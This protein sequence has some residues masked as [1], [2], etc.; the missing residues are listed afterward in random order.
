MF[1]PH[2]AWVCAVSLLLSVSAPLSA[3]Q[4]SSITGC[5]QDSTRAAIPGAAVI[6]TGSDGA[7]RFQTQADDKGCFNLSGLR[8]GKYRL[9]IFAEAFSAYEADIALEDPIRL[10]DIVLEIH[11]IQAEVVVTATRNLAPANTLGSSVDVIDRSRIE[12]SHIQTASD[13]LRNIGGLA[14]VRTGNAGGI[15]TLFTRGGNSDY[16]K[17]LVDGIPVNQPGGTYDF[18][19]L[20]ADNISTIE[21]VRG[22]QSALFGSDAL[23]GIVQMFT[24]RGTA[25][26]EAEYSLEG[27]N[28]G[29]LKQSTA[30]RGAWKR[31]DWSNTFSRLDTDN[32]QPNN[33]YR[34]AGYF[35]N[36]GFALDSK[37]TFRGTL[38]HVSSRIATPGVN[39]PGFTSFG[40]ND[41]AENLERAAGVTYSA[42]VSSRLTQH[43]A[44]R[45]YDHDYNYFSAF[46]VSN[47]AHKR[48]RAEYHGDVAL[49]LGSTFAYGVDFDREDANVA[50]VP[51]LRNNTGYYA[52]QQ[53]RAW[54]R[55]DLIGGI[56]IEDNTTFGV[57]ANPRFGASMRVRPDLR[58]RFSAGTGIKEPS[59]IQNFSTNRFFRGN[60]NLIPERS[61]SW[62]AGV[63]QSFSKNR[64]TADLAWFDNRFRN[65]IQL[66]SQPD[67]SGLYQ[68]IGRNLARGAEL[69]MRA[70]VRQLLVEANYT[71]LDGH[72]QESTQRSYPF[73]PGDPLLRR[74]RHSGDIAI[75]WIGPKWSAQWSTRT[76]GRRADSDFFTYRL[77]L[78]SNPGYSISDGSLTYEFRRFG[79]VYLRVEN[80]FNRDYQ[81]VLG[82]LSLR[83]S[84]V[85]GT[86][87]RLGRSK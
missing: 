26:P 84:F 47:I 67:F 21:V 52:Q 15:T 5:V 28:Y 77:P 79:S 65:L 58:L 7:G 32:I 3:R 23:T 57:S 64:I 61:R 42:L 8:S 50:G 78:T 51:H 25:P 35:G 6:L 46:G 2:P 41:H 12:A 82:Y 29:T 24:T 34:N 39:A 17:I 22:P 1:T 75:T 30:L 14:V 81:E 66:V 40:P 11:P 4:L 43:L 83:R 38:F 56:R 85:A 10:E 72:I 59:F 62:E 54:D 53:V 80:I 68:N 33:D 63:E 31:L 16:T 19:Y 44:Y 49:A 48:H 27:G 9:Q 87:I 76:A 71:Y 37:Q 74:P 55:L 86:R 69:R 60:P 20:P 36:F 73:R 18:A 70:R 13:L 45:Y